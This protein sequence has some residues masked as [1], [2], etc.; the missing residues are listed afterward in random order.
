MTRETKL[1]LVVAGSFLALVGGVV[2]VRLKQADNPPGE[3]EVVQAQPAETPPADPAAAP[4]EPEKP[5]VHP[6]SNDALAHAGAVKMPSA[7]EMKPAPVPSP[8]P[9]APPT[10]AAVQPA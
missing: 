1:G 5:R 9:D 7:P 10:P 4:T 2:A 8:V 6:V 3:A